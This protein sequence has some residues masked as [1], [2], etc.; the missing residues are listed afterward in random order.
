MKPNS[1]SFLCCVYGIA[2]AALWEEEEAS[3]LNGLRKCFQN[4]WVFWNVHKLL[5]GFSININ[6]VDTIAMFHFGFF[7]Y[8]VFVDD[9]VT[10]LVLPCRFCGCWYFHFHEKMRN[11]F[12]SVVFLEWYFIRSFVVSCGLLDLWLGGNIVKVH[13][14]YQSLWLEKLMRNLVQRQSSFKLSLFNYFY[15]C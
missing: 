2:V 11:Q 8:F 7:V 4:V 9:G 6:L 13:V 12:S 10:F 14:K 15:R 1:I 3:P 5:V